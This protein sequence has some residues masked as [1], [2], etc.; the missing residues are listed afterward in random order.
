MRPPKRADVVELATDGDADIRLASVRWLERLVP[1][2]SEQ[3]QVLERAT[4]DESPPVRRSSAAPRTP[5]SALLAAV[6]GCV[7]AQLPW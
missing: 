7:R 3:R 2:T 6:V 1:V 5:S 4:K